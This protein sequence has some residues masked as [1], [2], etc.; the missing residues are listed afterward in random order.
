MTKVKLLDEQIVTTSVDG[1]V[2]VFDLKMRKEIMSHKIGV[3]LVSLFTSNN[4]ELVFVGSTKSEIILFDKEEKEELTRF[5]GTHITKDYS[6]ELKL[7]S[8][9]SSIATTSENGQVVFYD[10]VSVSSVFSWVRKKW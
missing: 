3:P 8:D 9:Y 10:I 6:S 5:S 2:R 7:L 4:D 1:Y